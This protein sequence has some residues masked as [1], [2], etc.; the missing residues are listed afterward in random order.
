MQTPFGL[1]G[2]MDGIIGFVKMSSHFGGYPSNHF[3]SASDKH[4]VVFPIRLFQVL[5]G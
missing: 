3:A 4:T 5:F 2:L 1:A